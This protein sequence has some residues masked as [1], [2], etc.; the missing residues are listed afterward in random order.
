V[1]IGSLERDPPVPTQLPDGTSFRSFLGFK[2]THILSISL[3]DPWYWKELPAN[4]NGYVSAHCIRGVR[5]VR[6][7]QSSHL[8]VL[9][10]SNDAGI[11]SAI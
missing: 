7:N 1:L 9:K 3:R 10:N 11:A 5:K 8:H 2:E 6:Y 4:G